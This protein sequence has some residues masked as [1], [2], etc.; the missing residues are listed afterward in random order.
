[1][2][3]S[4]M[5]EEQISRRMGPGRKSYLRILGSNAPGNEASTFTDKEECNAEMAVIGVREFFSKIV[6]YCKAVAD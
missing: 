2:W 4:M 1:M 3:G 5:Y 6:K